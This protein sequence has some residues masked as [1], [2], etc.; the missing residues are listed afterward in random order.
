MSAPMDISMNNFTECNV[1][2]QEAP[3]FEPPAAAS[4][5]PPPPP[6]PPPL[7][8]EEKF[9]VSGK[10]L[11]SGTRVQKLSNLLTCFV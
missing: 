8:N 2:E 6:P 10:C 5:P 3:I 9:L 11:N 1:P 4:S 7:I